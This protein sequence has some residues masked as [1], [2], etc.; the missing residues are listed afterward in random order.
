MKES[1]K[2]PDENVLPSLALLPVIAALAG[3]AVMGLLMLAGA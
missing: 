1:I 2:A 3:A